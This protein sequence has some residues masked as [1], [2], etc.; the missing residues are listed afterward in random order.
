MAIETAKQIES[1]ENLELVGIYSH[2][3][4]SDEPGSDFSQNQLSLYNELLEKLNEI[5]ISPSINHFE[6]SGGVLNLENVEFGMVR[7]GIT[8]YG[9]HPTPDLQDDINLIQVMTLKSKVVQ[10]REIE[11]GTPVSYGGTWVSEEST[12]I[13]TVPIGYADGIHRALSNNM[14]VLIGGDRY[15]VVGRVTMDM[16]MVDIGD[17]RIDI[18]DEVVI[19]GKQAEE[20]I[21]IAEVAQKLDTI[22]YEITCAVSKRVPRIYVNK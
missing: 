2:L 5:G 19:Y 18:G 1:E 17:A 13:A 20:M 4:R 15:S 22:S 14:D 8:L 11:K 9:H 7:V 12:S 21:T 3:A 6:N 16:I 10:I